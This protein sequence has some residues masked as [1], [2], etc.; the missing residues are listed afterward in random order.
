M[1][2]QV[3]NRL[4]VINADKPSRINTDEPAARELNRLPVAPAWL[5]VSLVALFT[6]VCREPMAMHLRCASDLDAMLHSVYDVDLANRPGVL[7]NGMASLT[8]ESDTGMRA[9][10]AA[11]GHG[12]PRHRGG[13]P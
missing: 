13:A 10:D 7:I 4:K 5:T 3:P 8:L 11:D 12:Q 1:P 9:S 2:D 6:Q